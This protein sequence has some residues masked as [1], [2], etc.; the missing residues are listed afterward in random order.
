[1]WHLRSESSVPYNSHQNIVYETATRP[2]PV[3][4]S[5]PQKI[6]L[7]LLCLA[8][9]ALLA[10]YAGCG[11][12]GNDSDT[13]SLSSPNDG[14]HSQPFLRSRTDRAPD[15]TEPLDPIEDILSN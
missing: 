7:A 5:K 4:T 11:T 15:S 9:I 10:P 12:F 13:S 2:P 6:S 14:E 3:K 8:V 1:M